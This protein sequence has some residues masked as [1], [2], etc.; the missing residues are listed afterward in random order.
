MHALVMVW[1]EIWGDIPMHGT[2]QRQRVRY[3][4]QL[5]Q[6]HGALLFAGCEG[7]CADVDSCRMRA[8]VLALARY[9]APASD[10]LLC[11]LA[12][13]LEPGPA[14]LP[15]LQAMLRTLADA[16]AN[17]GTTVSTPSAS[18]PP[19]TYGRLVLSLWPRSSPPAQ[20][21]E[22]EE[23]LV[24]VFEDALDKGKAEASAT[25]KMG[26]E[27]GIHTSQHASLLRW[28]RMMEIAAAAL[29]EGAAARSTAAGITATCR[30]E[31]EA[32]M[33]A[34]ENGSH[35]GGVGREG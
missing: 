9:K 24:S 30:Q 15:R 23:A 6:Q 12:S 8:A 31:W 18:L 16:E 21:A 26:S 5:M 34:G 19:G 20:L 3:L 2:S 4:A 27:M 10:Q 32:L 22:A 11:A 25:A 17:S 1:D 33:A 14:R 35:A 28:L 7:G 13:S 29:P